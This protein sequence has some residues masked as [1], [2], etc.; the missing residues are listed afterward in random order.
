MYSKR[1]PSKAVLQDLVRSSPGIP[2]QQTNGG[3]RFT[4]AAA[5]VG[6]ERS[7]RL[8]TDSSED[9]IAGL[10]PLDFFV[11]PGSEKSVTDKFRDRKVCDRKVP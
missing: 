1:Q 8:N 6:G 3:R 9:R 11:H 5:P 4:V 7:A 10:V 2:A